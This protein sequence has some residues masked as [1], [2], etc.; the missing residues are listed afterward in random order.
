V[1][2]FSKLSRVHWLLRVYVPSVCDE[3]LYSSHEIYVFM[4]FMPFSEL[5]FLMKT[6]CDCVSRN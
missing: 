4:D 6:R 1:E 3:G 2:K 5:I